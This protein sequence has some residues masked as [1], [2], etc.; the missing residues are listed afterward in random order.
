MRRDRGE[1]GGWLLRK[2]GLTRLLRIC[3][4]I[5]LR[6]L[7]AVRDLTLRRLA[8]GRLALSERVLTL[9]RWSC[10]WIPPGT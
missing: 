7:L 9:G 10:H 1:P 6:R 8:V 3:L 5:S 2:P 4:R